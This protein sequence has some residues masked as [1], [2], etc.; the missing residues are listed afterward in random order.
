MHT[1]CS[2]HTVVEAYSAT[3]G[4]LKPTLFTNLLHTTPLMSNLANL[5]PR[6]TV[7]TGSHDTW[8]KIQAHDTS[9]HLSF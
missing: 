5:A 9:L 6:Q 2:G 3:L 8:L 4:H 7:W 1:T